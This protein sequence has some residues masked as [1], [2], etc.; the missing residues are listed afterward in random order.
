MA[1]EW[2]QKHIEELIKRTVDKYSTGGEATALTKLSPPYTFHFP[3]GGFKDNSGGYF[4]EAQSYENPAENVGEGA[5]LWLG[6]SVWKTGENLTDDVM[7]ETA[8]QD[9]R[10]WYTFD[11]GLQAM[12]TEE[13]LDFTGSA[14]GLG[15]AFVN[16]APIGDRG[17]KLV[18]DGL[19][20]VIVKVR[21]DTT[22]QY[23]VLNLDVPNI[24]VAWTGAAGPEEG[25]FEVFSPNSSFLLR[26]KFFHFTTEFAEWC[27]T[28]LREHLR[29][30][31]LTHFP[32]LNENTTF[33]QVFFHCELTGSLSMRGQTTDYSHFFDET[34]LVYEKDM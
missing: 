27:R 23:Y 16:A 11:R 17:L 28:T 33:V 34:K 3:F 1:R 14:F 15:S 18:G 2:T 9:Y 8:S 7:Y 30:F 10:T 26:V 13:R 12:W 24:D 32:D 29:Q 6:N 5:I 20:R 19:E 31:I 4:Y 21:D 25:G 22:E